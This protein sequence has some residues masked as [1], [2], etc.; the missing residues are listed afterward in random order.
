LIAVQTVKI[1]GKEYALAMAS[2]LQSVDEVMNILNNISW[3]AYVIAILFSLILAAII[4]KLVAKPLLK[5]IERK[6]ILDSMRK[7][8]IA[9][10]SHEMKTPISIISG[11]AESLI[12]GILLPEERIEYEH[13]IYDEAQKMEKLVRDMLEI[14]MLQRDKYEPQKVEVRLDELIERTL[15]RLTGQIKEKKLIVIADNL[16]AAA[17]FVDERM[18]ETVFVNFISNAM[19]HTS[20]GGSI[21]I[22]LLQNNE[23]IRFEI[24]NEGL[25][26]PD[27]A[28]VHIWESFYRVDK[29][30]DRENGRFGLGL[31]A[32]KTI[33]EKHNGTVGMQNTEKGVLF[34]FAI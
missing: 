3:L 16:E 23:G 6:N 34:Y 17:T 9:N 1:N 33:I 13:T 20:E 2:S 18:M 21:W 7:D 8:F 10:A 26:I 12:D 30:H 5:E 15:K 32:V 31:F 28:V 14:A 25:P 22:R 4:A 11:Y 27:E 24:E 19:S 29:S